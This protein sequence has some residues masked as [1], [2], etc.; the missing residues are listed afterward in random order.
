MPNWP[1]LSVLLWDQQ[2]SAYLGYCFAHYRENTNWD[3]D[4]SQAQNSNYLLFRSLRLLDTNVAD[5]SHA[6][7]SIVLMWRHYGC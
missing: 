5:A 4:G 2:G 6:N 1:E 3:V 7:S